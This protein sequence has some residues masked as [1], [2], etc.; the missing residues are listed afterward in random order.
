VA[1]AARVLVLTPTLDGRDGLSCLARQY[2]EAVAAALPAAQVEVHSLAEAAPAAR[3]GVR[4]V[5]GAGGS[6]AR[7]VWR[8]IVRAVTR[9]PTMVVALHAPLLPVA[10]PSIWRGARL[11]TVLVG[12]EAWRPFAPLQAAAFG[13]SAR[14]IAISAHTAREFARANPGAGGPAIQVCW[15]ATP[16]LAPPDE[17]ASIAPGYALIVGRMWSEE[18]YKGHDELL[19]AWPRVLEAVPGARLLVAGT[20][21]DAERLR[22]RSEQEGLGGAVQFLGPVEP[23]RLSALYRDA[24]LVVMPSAREGFGYVFLEAMSAGR[25]CIGAAGAAAEIIV[26]GET[27]VVVEPGDIPALASA[28]SRL[29][30]DAALR[31][32]MGRAGLERAER[33]FTMPRLVRDLG[34]VLAPLAGGADTPC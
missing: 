15:P 21:D 31:D 32:R 22:R 10:L 5:R 26:D 33:V 17:A 13:H 18:R 2:A 16:A 19:T 25:A 28:L 34:A 27:G 29:L 8:E 6:R 11:V 3:A 14:V 12:V 9:P 1:D 20:G 30:G 24:A 7:F 23:S 4:A